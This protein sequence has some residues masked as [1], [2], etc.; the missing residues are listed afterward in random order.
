MSRLRRGPMQAGFEPYQD[1]GGQW[2]WRLFAA[3]GLV[4]ATGNEG[5]NSRRNCLRAIRAV[6]VL[7]GSLA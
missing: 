6:K 3:N 5:F 1:K 2:R 4:V 7:L